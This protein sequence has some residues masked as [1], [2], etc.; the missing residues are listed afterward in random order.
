MKR[1]IHRGEQKLQETKAQDNERFSSMQKR[2][3]E[4]R[5]HSDKLDA[6]LE[7][8]ERQERALYRNFKDEQKDYRYR[9]DGVLCSV[10][11]SL[12]RP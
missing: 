8:F 10:V 12:L 7:D 4:L 1:E 6:K 9:I 11:G 5:G 3:A 2:E